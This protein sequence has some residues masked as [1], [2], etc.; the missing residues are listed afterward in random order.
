M[1]ELELKYILKSH[2]QLKSPM[3]GDERIGWS[4]DPKIAVFSG[5]TIAFVASQIAAYIA[6][7]EVSIFGMD[8]GNPGDVPQRSYSENGKPR[9]TSIDRD[10]HSTILPAFQC[11]KSFHTGCKF[12]N[13]SL[14]SKLPSTVIEKPNEAL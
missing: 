11:I 2:E 13:M 6:K 5:R 4:R 12:F 8:L 14:N 7:D 9:P 1:L 3:D 10:Y